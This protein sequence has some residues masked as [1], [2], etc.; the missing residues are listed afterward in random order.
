MAA[1]INTRCPIPSNP[2]FVH[3]HGQARRTRL[4]PLV[5]GGMPEAAGS[6]IVAVYAVDMSADIAP[7]LVAVVVKKLSAIKTLGRPQRY[8]WIAQNRDNR[9]TLA[10]SSERYTNRA[11]CLSAAVQLFADAT[12]D[13]VLL[14]QAGTG[15]F[16][17]PSNVYLI[18]DGL[19]GMQTLRL[20]AG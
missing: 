8:Y 18:Q 5:L 2:A 4:L 20:H 9:E 6:G 17:Q 1:T 19:S 16:W 15:H 11:D 3:F 13:P 7:P 10:V 14:E 12:C